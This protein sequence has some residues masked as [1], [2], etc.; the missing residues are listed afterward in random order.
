MPPRLKIEG[1]VSS[2]Y[3]YSLAKC[4][5]PVQGDDV[6]GYITAT[7]GLKIHRTNCPNATRLAARYG[8]R[9]MKAEW[10]STSNTDFIAEL[11]ITG[12][13]DGPGVIERLTHNISSGQGLNIRSF[14][15]DGL[16][17][18]FEGRMKIFVTNKDQLNVAIAALKKLSGVINV[19]RVKISWKMEVGSGKFPVIFNLLFPPKIIYLS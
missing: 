3:E 16:E 18:K 15:I 9:I 6:F 8:Y 17:G 7:A 5:S 1:E 12:I 14:S 13:D 2:Q 11:V 19:T 10:E 4:C